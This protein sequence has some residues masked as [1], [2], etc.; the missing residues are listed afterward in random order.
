[1]LGVAIR[2]GQDAGEILSNGQVGNGRSS[3]RDELPFA[4]PVMPRRTDSR[5]TEAWRV[6]L[7]DL[8]P[9]FYHTTRSYKV[10]AF[11]SLRGL[12][13]ADPFEAILRV[14]RIENCLRGINY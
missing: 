8:S 13:E 3:R 12:L 1:M 11:H 9:V 2:K 6:V 4:G 5:I 10:K 14:E 7:R